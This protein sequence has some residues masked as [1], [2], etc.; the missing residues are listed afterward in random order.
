[1]VG[2]SGVLKGSKVPVKTGDSVTGCLLGAG[3][4]DC[5]CCGDEDRLASSAAVR[6]TRSVRVFSEVDT[7]TEVLLQRRDRKRGV[8]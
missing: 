1:M 7:E 3:T 4:R 5:C 8:V 6:R 2:G